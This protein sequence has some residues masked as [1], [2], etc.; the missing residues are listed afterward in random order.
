[1]LAALELGLDGVD[2]PLVLL[3]EDAILDVAR[4]CRLRVRDDLKDPGDANHRY[5]RHQLL[6][7]LRH[8]RRVRNTLRA[9]SLRPQRA[10]GAFPRVC[11][12]P[13][14]QSPAGRAFRRRRSAPQAVATRFRPEWPADGAVDRGRRAQSGPPRSRVQYW[15][16]VRVRSFQ[17]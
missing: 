7:R 11:A 17:A 10:S 9:I 15:P 5:A 1:M 14:R 13:S 3:V 8:Q 4:H 16:H 12:C 6:C 2:L